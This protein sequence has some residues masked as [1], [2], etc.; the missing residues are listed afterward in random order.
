MEL[1]SVVVPTYNRARLVP[2][3]VASALAAMQPGDELIVVDDGSTDDTEAA[4]APFR[5]R[6]RYFRTENRGV[7]PA[8]NH[9]L[10]KTVHPLVTFLDSDDEWM[11]DSLA[12]R[13]AVLAARPDLVFCFT[14]FSFKDEQ[15]RVTEKYLVNWHHDTRDW[16]EILGSGIPFSAMAALPAGRADFQ[17]HIGNLYPP[18]LE[19]C[20]VPA[21]TSLIRKS[22]AG[23]DLEFAEDLP[24][25]EEWS[26]FGRAARRAPVAF[27]DCDTAWN[28][29][30]SGARVTSD[31]GL[32]GFLTG[33]ITLAKR[34]WGEDESF[35]RTESARYRRVMESIHLKRARWFLSRG[36]TLEARADLAAAGAAAPMSLRLLSAVP[37]PL[38]S[39]MGVVR[40]ASHA[41]L[42]RVRS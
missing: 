12:L 16:N 17:V 39:A 10:R 4:L 20:Y 33:H 29:G 40:R 14:D 21:W 3:A 31:A 34:I 42:H 19:R 41:L 27:L 13:R 28:H 1:V 9:G 5:D 8:R 30:H 37:G 24:L 11:P 32:V 35:L 38:M 25:G 23:D 6:I 36:H 22:V 2:R 7:G 15:G 18:L 26:L